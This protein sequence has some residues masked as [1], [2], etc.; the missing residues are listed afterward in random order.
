MLPDPDFMLNSSQPAACVRS[1]ILLTATGLPLAGC[2]KSAIRCSLIRSRSW[3]R[4]VG[5][6]IS[7]RV[8]SSCIARTSPP[9]VTPSSMTPEALPDLVLALRVALPLVIDVLC[10]NEDL[11]ESVF[12]L[13]SSLYRSHRAYKE[14]ISCAMVATKLML[15]FRPAMKP[16]TSCW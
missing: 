6:I 10:M 5:V 15:T 3:T 8:L 11:A 4:K 1:S 16:M 7:L 9:A 2:A 13:G 12:A 14:M